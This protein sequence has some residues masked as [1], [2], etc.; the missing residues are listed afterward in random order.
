M[1]VAVN[2]ST[3]PLLSDELLEST[4][5]PVMKT[6]P[7]NLLPH[8]PQLPA[9]HTTSLYTAS[10]HSVALTM[11]KVLQLTFHL[12]T[13]QQPP[14]KFTY[15]KHDDLE[16][17]EEDFQTVALDDNHW[18]TDQIPDRHLCPQTF[19]TTFPMS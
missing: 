3:Y 17:E 5:F 10:Y 6:A 2:F 11:K 1:R 14:Y 7:S 15:T 16:E 13:A 18:T 8:A 12:I 19:T 9:S 4:M